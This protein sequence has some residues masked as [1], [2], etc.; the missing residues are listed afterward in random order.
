MSLANRRLRMGLPPMEMNI[1]WSKN[2]CAWASL[3]TSWTGWVRLSIPIGHQLLSWK[4]PLAVCSRG[5]YCW[6]SHSALMAEA[7][8]LIYLSFRG[9][10]TS[11]HARLCQTPS[12]SLMLLVPR[13]G[14][15]TID[16]FFYQCFVFWNIF[17]FFIPHS[18]THS[19][20]T[21]ENLL[22]SQAFR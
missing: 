10:S 3:G 22:I 8:L 4:I 1:W 7:A 15:L 5:I 17:F 14:D 6:S 12:W 18:E 16:H 13:Y 21:V 19:S 9:P 20:F 11:L 2:V